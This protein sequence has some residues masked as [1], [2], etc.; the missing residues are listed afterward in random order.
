MAA[1]A[2]ADRAAVN[3]EFQEL[4][5]LARETF[6][7]MTKAELRAAVDA[8][9]NWIVS[10]AAAFNTAIPQPARAALTVSQKARLFSLIVYKRYIT[11]A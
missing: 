3:K 2:D 7:A 8:I 5:S 10:N 11:G 9:D 1:L 4:I 6:G